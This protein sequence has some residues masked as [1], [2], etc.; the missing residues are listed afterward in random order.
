M[1]LL[2][3]KTPPPIGG[4]TIH[5]AR[6]LKELEH[7]YSNG[8]HHFNLSKSNFYR[9]IW[10]IPQYTVIHLHTSSTLFQ[11]SMAIYC[12]ML[13]KPLIITYHGN[14]GRYGRIRSLLENRSI[15]NC[16]IPIVQNQE[17][18]KVACVLNSR[19]KTIT[20]YL[21]S[22]KIVPLPSHILEEI[23]ALKT[24][25]RYIFCTN[26]W[27]VSFDRAG[28]EIYG[29]SA[30]LTCS[31]NFQNSVLIISDPSGN[32]QKRTELFHPHVYWISIPHDFCAVLQMADAFIRNTSTDATCISI[33]EALSFGKIVFATNAVSRPARCITYQNVK[34]IALEGLLEME[35]QKPVQNAASQSESVN[36]SDFVW[37]Y[38]Q[39]QKRI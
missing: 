29:I 25:Y 4:V 7:R 26:A 21:P 18:Y 35:K 10:L 6:F 24:Q 2:I 37:M 30:L 13:G 34:N 14:L 12:L 3:G 28:N 19:T 39:L 9:L 38:E 32:Q 8:F 31:D 23:N 22:S 15:A 5:L 20:T 36:I 17:S 33:H 16:T 11:F 1:V 27:N